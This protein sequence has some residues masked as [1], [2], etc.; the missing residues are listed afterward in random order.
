MAKQMGCTITGRIED[1]SFYYDSSHGYLVRRTGG[2]SSEE[3]KTD[4]RYTAAG[5]ASAEFAAVSRAGKLIRD[6]F[7][8]FIQ[9]V[10]DGT[11]VNRL[12]RELVALKQADTKHCRGER[13]A[14]T[15]MT[16]SDAN[17]WMRIFQF[18]EGVKVFELFEGFPIVN[19]SGASLN[20]AP[21][22]PLDSAFPE[23]ATHA[24]LMLVRSVIDFEK[25]CFETRASRMVL[26]S[27]AGPF[28]HRQEL[29][30]SIDELPLMPG[31]E[32]VC[33][34]VL[35]FEERDGDFVQ[36]KGRIHGMGIVAITKT[37]GVS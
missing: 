8:P 32:I 16:D 27:K 24:G 22:R 25:G 4:E 29:S 14:E 1:Y 35:F 34:Q 15:M 30:L 26:V 2:V 11:M 19:T 33:L 37:V 12:N 28:L 9:Q 13:R 7:D 20:L 10:K 23:V 5:N 36:L 3:Y 6:A 18:N 17:K 21:A 31:T